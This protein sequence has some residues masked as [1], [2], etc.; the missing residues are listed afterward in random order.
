MARFTIAFS[1]ALMITS[2][3]I[4]Q[5][6]LVNPGFDDP[7]QLDGW[8]CT[9]SDGI[10]FWSPDDHAGSVGSGSMQ[11]EVSGTTD[12]LR[13]R[14]WQCV[15][16]RQNWPYAGSAWYYWPDDSDVSQDGKTVITVSFFSD[17]GCTV[18]LG[19]G[20]GKNAGPVLDTWV[21][22]V[23]SELIAPG[24]TMSAGF[25]VFTWQYNADQPVRARLDDLVFSPIILFWDDFESGGTGRWTA[26]SP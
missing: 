4:A 17:A 7:D 5:N 23:T 25:Y 12:D 21:Q 9:T 24:G 26:T 19:G 18:S 16:A 22:A 13:V 1:I 11:H 10:A 15:P 3:V 8:T 2:P 14:C 6:L 20:G